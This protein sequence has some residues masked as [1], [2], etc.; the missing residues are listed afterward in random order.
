MFNKIKQYLKSWTINF[1]LLL[2]LV[3]GLQVYIDGLGNPAA[4]MLIGFI[5]VGLRFKTT[6]PVSEK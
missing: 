5:V 1:G 2:Q 6:R 3:A 4:T